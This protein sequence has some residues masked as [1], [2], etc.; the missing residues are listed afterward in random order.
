MAD[1]KFSPAEMVGGTN[2]RGE[3]VDIPYEKIL[4]MT[5]KATLVVIAGEEIW[6]PKSMVGYADD[7]IIC[8]SEWLAKEK[9]ISS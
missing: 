9:V 2:I 6:I 8:I 1:K 5:D 4:A 3:T 7:E